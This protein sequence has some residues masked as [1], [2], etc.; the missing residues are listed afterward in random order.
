MM[1]FVASSK[2]AVPVLNSFRLPATFFLIAAE[3]TL[4]RESTTQ[5][6][7]IL[8]KFGFDNTERCA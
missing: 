7:E 1:A 2:R 8:D 5:V 6:P 3:V 4:L